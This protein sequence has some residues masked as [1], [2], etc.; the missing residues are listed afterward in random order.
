[1]SCD[2]NPSALPRV[3][4]CDECGFLFEEGIADATREGEVRCPQ[5]GLSNVRE[6]NAL[7]VEDFVL[8]Q[9]MKFR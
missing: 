4:R 8:R 5:C 3:F 2:L 9:G 7:E 6:V 1:M